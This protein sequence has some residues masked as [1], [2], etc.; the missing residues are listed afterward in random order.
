MKSR[1]LLIILFTIIALIISGLVLY[2]KIRT[3]VGNGILGPVGVGTQ[4]IMKRRYEQGK[5]IR[6][7]FRSDVTDDQALNL[8]N[9]WKQLPDINGSSFTSSKI[10]GKTI[11]D[12]FV[13]DVEKKHGV[14][15]LVEQ[16]V[17]VERVTDGKE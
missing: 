4:E 13:I 9:E 8:M 16:N 1:K 5:M 17:F 7:Y 10:S 3:S 6:I 15:Q 2:L 12:L 14:I 11:V